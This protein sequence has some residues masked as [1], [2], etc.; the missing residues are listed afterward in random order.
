[1]HIQSKVKVK[2]VLMLRVIEKELHNVSTLNIYVYDSR[3][4][5]KKESVERKK[6]FFLPKE[7]GSMA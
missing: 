4:R 6:L 5:K 1:M 7:H 3:I 2:D